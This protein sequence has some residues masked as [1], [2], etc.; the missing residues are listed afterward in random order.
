M[1]LQLEIR[2]RGAHAAW[3]LQ[4]VN[5]V[6]EAAWKILQLE[7][8][9]EETGVTCSCGMIQGGTAINSVPERCTVQVDIRYF[10]NEQLNWARQ[11][12][13]EIAQT[14]LSLIHISL[15]LYYPIIRT[16]ESDYL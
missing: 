7:K 14:C 2:G 9:K 13:A 5:A 8:L 6:A 12:V 1:H 15:F 4:G 16:G 10:T 3:C 11:R